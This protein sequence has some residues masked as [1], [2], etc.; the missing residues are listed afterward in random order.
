MITRPLNGSIVAAK[1]PGTTIVGRSS[2]VVTNATTGS[3]FV[4][5]IIE[6]VDGIDDAIGAAG[7]LMAHVVGRTD[8]ETLD[9]EPLSFGWVIPGSDAAIVL[10]RGAMTVSV[11]D[12]NQETRTFTGEAVT[13]WAEHRAERP[14]QVAIMLPIMYES[15]MSEPSWSEYEQSPMDASALWWRAELAAT[16]TVESAEGTSAD[17][18]PG[19]VGDQLVGQQPD[20]EQ[21]VDQQPETPEE[22][23]DE[24]ANEMGNRVSEPVE[25][26]I[27]DDQD[28][29]PEEF[30]D[31]SAPEATSPDVESLPGR[32]TLEPEPPAPESEPSATADPDLEVAQAWPPPLPDADSDLGVEFVEQLGATVTRSSV[33]PA[34]D[35][36]E[37]ATGNS[38]PPGLTAIAEGPI[39]T[40]DGHDRT[41]DFN[42]EGMTLGFD[43]D[44]PFGG[45]QIKNEQL[46]AD[47]PEVEDPHV[48]PS[49][50]EPVI[51]DVDRTALDTALDTALATSGSPT[52]TPQHDDAPRLVPSTHVEAPPTSSKPLITG[53]PSSDGGTDGGMD[54]GAH[55]SDTHIPEVPPID[56]GAPTSDPET[57]A[58][59]ARTSP[60]SPG[61]P[62]PV[63]PE[64]PL[65]PTPPSSPT[66]P[67]PPSPPASPTP[68]VSHWYDPVEPTEDPVESEPPVN[69]GITVTAVH[70]PSAHSNPP[71]AE[72]CRICNQ[73]I[74]DRSITVIPRPLLGVLRFSDGRIAPVDGPLLL[75][76][77]PSGDYMVNGQLATAITIDD[78][79]RSLSRNHVELRVSDWQVHIVDRDST[80]GTFLTIPGRAPF[81]LRAGESYPTPLNSEVRL[82][83]TVS[84]TFELHEPH[85]S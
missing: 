8:N 76:R 65:A 4:K 75:G 77:R 85:R 1:G 47:N 10:V 56:P 55:P 40:S 60:V 16:T 37:R 79:D 48:E 39:T 27:D 42:E 52:D 30:Q 61:A 70:C 14:E 71:H 15:V 2:L 74:T 32:N 80:N 67:I 81:R 64:S 24:I 6:A 31:P 19:P 73:P 36:E 51:A 17:A 29:E 57:S 34:T 23:A 72:N 20:G 45:T 26:A 66:P 83:D 18:Q 69:A 84:F 41:S 53:F 50:V 62:S 13:T 28:R 63:V 46:V 78:P 54:R 58:P 7:F 82:S 21:P 25:F 12:G 9:G 38:E 22:Q 68:R 44:Q 3:E 33:V 11:L 59:A 43:D 5:R 49:E 35:V